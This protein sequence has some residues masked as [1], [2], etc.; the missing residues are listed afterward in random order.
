MS[1]SPGA[2]TEM[3]RFVLLEHRWNGVHWDFMLEHGEVL[4]SW[5]IAAPVVARKELPARELGDHRRAYLEYE[6]EVSGNRGT[7]RRIDRG[8]YTVV[9]W[10][11]ERVR[12]RLNGSQ[13]V[14]DVELCQVGE[15]SD[16]VSSW[17]F[18]LGNLD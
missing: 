1:V 10:S 7:V 13:L 11:A 4:R 18:R 9:F 14:G 16:G 2:Q 8:T 15:S 5:A 12:V 3:P 17:I 6:G